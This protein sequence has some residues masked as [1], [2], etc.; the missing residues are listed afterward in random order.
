MSVRP[1]L[2]IDASCLSG[3]VFAYNV[4]EFAALGVSKE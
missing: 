1:F 2:I 3:C 4:G